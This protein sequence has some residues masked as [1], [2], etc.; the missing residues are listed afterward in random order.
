MRGRLPTSP[1]LLAG[2]GLLLALAAPASAQVVIDEREDIDFDRPEAWAMKLFASINTLTGLGVPSEEPAGAL[3]LDLEVAS[4]PSLSKEQRTVGFNGAKEEDL[5]RSSVFVRP[6]LRV[7]LPKKLTLDAGWVPPIETNGVLANLLSVSLGRPVYETSR[8][9]LGLRLYAQGGTIEG[10]FTCSAEN[11][12]AGADFELNPFG[13][14]APSKDEQSVRSL[15]LELGWAW[16]PPGDSRWEPHV[17]LLT[18]WMDL[19]FQVNAHYSGLD[20]RTLLVTD[21][22]T[23][24]VVAGT[25]FRLSKRFRLSGELFYSPLEVVRPPETTA[26]QDDL[27][28]AR[29]ALRYRVNHLGP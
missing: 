10:D 8:W 14:E 6:R 21:G 7:G 2:L 9:R 11:A 27:F 29:V 20:D 4:I 13:C 1:T 12:A 18:T 3:E 19:E 22:T 23:F 15:G 26:E 28:H 16:S 25:A 17:G 5:N 24:A